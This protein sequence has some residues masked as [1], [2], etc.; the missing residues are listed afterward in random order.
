MITLRKPNGTKMET[1]TESLQ[2][3]LVQLIPEDKNKED[4]IYHVTIWEQ[5]KQ[6]VYTTDDKEFTKEEFR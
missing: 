3:M 5:S 1:M 4:T 2:L 6:P